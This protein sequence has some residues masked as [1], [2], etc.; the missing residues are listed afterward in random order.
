MS[1]ATLTRSFNIPIIGVI[2][3]G[4]RKA[5]QIRDK[6]IVGVIGTRATVS[7]GA[8]K[9]QLKKIKPSLKVIS[10]PCPL[11]VPLVEE[12]WLN[13]GVTSHIIKEYLD[14][15]KKKKVELLILGCTH[16]PLLKPAI[17]RYMGKGVRLVDSAHET[18]KMV[19]DILSRKGLLSKKRRFFRHRYFVTDEPLA[20][21][22]V[23]EMFLGSRIES[24]KK[25]RI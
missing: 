7:S 3:P 18:A 25:V 2:K 20:F 10:K 1:L 23:G 9:T 21:K 15:F 24:I 16:Y 11:F 4:V 14:D 6:G 17:R 19:K 8:Y 5:L 12:G 22:K 13:N